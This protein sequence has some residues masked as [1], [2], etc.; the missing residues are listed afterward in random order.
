MRADDLVPARGLPADDRSVQ[1]HLIGLGHGEGRVEE[2]GVGDRVGGAPGLL[3]SLLARCAAPPQ[4]PEIDPRP[5]YGVDRDGSRITAAVGISRHDPTSHF[6]YRTH[7][8]RRL[9]G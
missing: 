3:Q 2:G 9:P 6:Q 8:H 7:H 5:T 4:F 1:G